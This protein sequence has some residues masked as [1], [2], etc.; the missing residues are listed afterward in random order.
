MCIRMYLHIRTCVQWW[1][2]TLTSGITLYLHSY[3]HWSVL[4]LVPSKI[5]R[6]LKHSS[7]HSSAYALTHTYL[8]TVVVVYI[9]VGYNIVSSLILLLVGPTPHAFKNPKMAPAFILSYHSCAY[10]YTYTSVHPYS[11]SSVHIVR[12]GITLYLYSYSMCSSYS[13]VLLPILS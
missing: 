3:C 9:E 8:R 1:F 10:T 4:P 7:Y 2:C 12:S 6:W 5:P 13:L 11:S